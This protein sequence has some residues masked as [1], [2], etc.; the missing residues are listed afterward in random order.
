MHDLL[1]LLVK[2]FSL[3]CFQVKFLI[4]DLASVLKGFGEHI[5]F[6]KMTGPEYILSQDPLLNA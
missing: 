6:S 5:V 3:F 2:D 1:H 4:P